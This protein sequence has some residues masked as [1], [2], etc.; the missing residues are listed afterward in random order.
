MSVII[1]LCFLSA[2]SESKISFSDIT[3]MF[4]G[5]KSDKIINLPSK[6]FFTINI[7]LKSENLRYIKNR[8]D[9]FILIF[10]G[11]LAQKYILEHPKY[12]DCPLLLKNI[13]PIYR[14]VKISTS[15]T[16]KSKRVGE[17]Y[18]SY[19]DLADKKKQKMIIHF[20]NAVLWMQHSCISCCPP[21]FFTRG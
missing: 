21:N 11:F 20:C 18:L 12:S 13:F 1:Y 4:Q 5:R 8:Q 2:E 3:D 17:K 19:L 14:N 7:L 15:F 10:F 6:C 9:R 16:A